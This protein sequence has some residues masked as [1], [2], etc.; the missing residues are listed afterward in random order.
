MFIDMIDFF[1]PTMC[2]VGSRGLGSLKGVLLGSFSHY[3]VQKSPVPVMVARKRLKLPPL[4]KGK[5]DVVSNVRARHMRL[6]QAMIEKDANVAEDTPEKKESE[7]E[8]EME[9]TA[10]TNKDEVVKKEEE[11]DEHVEKASSEKDIDTP[12]N[13]GSATTKKD[14]DDDK[15]NGVRK[16]SDV[17]AADDDKGNLEK[18]QREEEDKRQTEEIQKDAQEASELLDEKKSGKKADKKLDSSSIQRSNSDSK[19]TRG[20]KKFSVGSHPE[21]EIS[22]EEEESRGRSRSRSRN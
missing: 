14:S 17:Q 3:C 8:D 22:D 18:L 16:S 13:V 4:P 20:R 21:D 19:Q 11:K 15:F 12:A 1:E 2:V 7:K 6:D 5:T 10:K 9:E